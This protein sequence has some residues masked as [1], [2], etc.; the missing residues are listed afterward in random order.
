M[1]LVITFEQNVLFHLDAGGRSLLMEDRLENCQLATSNF[2]ILLN[3]SKKK[4]S[5]IDNYF[6]IIFFIVNLFPKIQMK[7]FGASSAS[8]GSYL[9]GLQ[10]RKIFGEGSRIH[11]LLVTMTLL[12]M[13][14]ILEI[15]LVENSR[16]EPTVSN[17]FCRVYITK[18]F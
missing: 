11:S 14:S 13:Y 2:Y 17:K 18:L 7:A 10:A 9:F 5:Q 8:S 16:E 12:Y 4:A 6:N 15:V 3:N 1:M